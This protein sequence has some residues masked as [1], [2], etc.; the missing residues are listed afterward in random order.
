MA[1][2]GRR[3]E[4]WLAQTV[5]DTSASISDVNDELNGN[6]CYFFRAREMATISG[7]S[8]LMVECASRLCIAAIATPECRE[9]LT[10]LSYG[11]KSVVAV[12]SSYAEVIG[13]C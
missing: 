6:S 3:N 4:L 11:L 9:Q 7:E 8:L 12:N 2:K 5:A 1:R 10:E 13:S